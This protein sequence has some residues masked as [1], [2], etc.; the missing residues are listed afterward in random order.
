MERR[1]SVGIGVI[2]ARDGMVL[3]RK[4]AGAHAHG[5]WSCPGG[6][7]EHGETPEACAIRETLEETGL[8]IESA[9]IVALTNDVFPD[10]KHYVTLWMKARGIGEGDVVTDPAEASEHGWFP[11][12]AL[13][14]PLFPSMVNLLDGGSVIPFDPATI[15]D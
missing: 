1:P 11:P 4:R 14:S 7:L 15:A 2:V 10:G 8:R 13:P 12:D 5:T 3:L 9:A 6:H